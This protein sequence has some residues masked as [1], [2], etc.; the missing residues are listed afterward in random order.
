MK[1]KIIISLL[2]VVG[3]YIFCVP[4]GSVRLSIFFQSPVKAFTTDLVDITDTYP[5]EASEDYTNGYKIYKLT[6]PPH[7][8]AT[9]NYITDWIVYR[10]G[11]FHF[12]K[13]IGHLV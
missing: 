4:T 8:E 11:I 2:I 9:D 1:K 5:G 13:S 6:N 7:E 10:I 3:I 12:S